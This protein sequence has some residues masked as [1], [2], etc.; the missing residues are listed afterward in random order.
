MTGVPAVVS[1][2]REEES[3]GFA[4]TRRFASS[5]GGHSPVPSSTLSVTGGPPAQNAGLGA[6]VRLGLSALRTAFW[7]F[8][9]CSTRHL[10]R[11]AGHRLRRAPAPFWGALMGRAGRPPRM[12][13]R[14][15]A[16]ALP[17]V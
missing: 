12:R 14:R 13:F 6:V 11:F 4:P 8:F 9:V 3:A 17:D 15:F 2:K 1:S 10:T 7:P 5:Q 16:L